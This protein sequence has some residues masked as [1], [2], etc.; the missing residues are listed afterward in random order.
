MKVRKNAPGFRNARQ[1]RLSIGLSC[2]TIATTKRGV[3]NNVTWYEQVRQR[4]TSD[5]I[6]SMTVIWIVPWKAV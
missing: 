5:C 1:T 3:L 6:G 4:V 2:P